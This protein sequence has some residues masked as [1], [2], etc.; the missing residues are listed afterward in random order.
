VGDISLKQGDARKAKGM[1]RRGL[2]E[3]PN[4]EGCKTGMAEC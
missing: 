3:D 1:F 4:H 2:D